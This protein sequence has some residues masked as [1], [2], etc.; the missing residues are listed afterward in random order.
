MSTPAPSAR[1]VFAVP[2]IDCASCVR[3]IR[4][5]LGQ[6]PGVADID[7]DL[8]TRRVTVA[9]DPRQVTEDGLRE[10]L[11]RLGFAPEDAPEAAGL[12][13]GRLAS[14][15]ADRRDG[16]DPALRYALLAGGVALL[17]LAGYAGYV[18]YPRF[19][20]PAV[21]GAGVL[22]LAAGAGIAS[23]FSPCSFPLLVTLLGREASAQS[24]TGTVEASGGRAFAFA[25]ALATGAA[26]FM[27]LLGVLIALGGEAL[28]GGVT[29]TSTTGRI[30][31]AIV[32][33]VL[34]TLGLIQLGL[35]PSPFHAVEAFSRPLMRAQARSRRSRPILGFGVLGFG[36]VLAGFG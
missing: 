13:T 36:Y 30:L 21:E 25:G 18:L 34:I 27:L 1:A 22:L 16:G 35:L 9:Y 29:F 3:A 14:A 19:G 15:Q 6:V 23:F 33:P 24:R 11:D 5:G 32:G 12:E 31:R 10:H 20:L 4:G 8:D 2:T 7:V 17:A 28:V 26:L